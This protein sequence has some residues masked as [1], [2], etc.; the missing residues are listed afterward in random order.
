[1]NENKKI[2]V[3]SFIIFLRLCLMTFIGIFTSRI[4]LDKLGASDFG[5]YNVVGGVVLLLNIVNTSML[6]TTYRYIAFELGKEGK[7]N[8]NKVFNA[9]FAI[10]GSY[11]LLIL[12]LGFTIGDWYVTNYINLPDG[13]LDDALFVFHLSLLAASINTLL[14]PFRGLLV[15]FENFSIS[16]IIDVIAKILYFISVVFILTQSDNGLI[17]YG[18]IHTVVVI[19]ESIGYYIYSQIKFLDIIRFRIVKEKS[20][21]K[22]MF[23]FSVWT[24]YGAVSSVGRAQGSVLI[25]NYFFGTLVNAAYA[26][27][28]QVNNFIK[29]FAL[30]LNNAAVPQITKNYSGGNLNRSVDLACYISKYTFILMTLVAFPVILEMDFLLSLWLKEVPEGTTEFCQWMILISLITTIGEGIYPLV[31]A[32]GKLKTFQLILCT[33]SLLGL[34]IAYIIYYLGTP[35]ISILILFFLMTFISLFIRL[36]LFL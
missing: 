20:I 3:N 8:T 29:S 22:G 21:Y 35:P 5:L 17:I 33:F 7:G 18:L 36:Y 13:R 31:Q 25:I 26:V 23:S 2:A 19:F 27:A 15:A 34:P 12:L 14:V 1:M 30:S 10:H 9:S 28:V 11:G 32:S 4:V 16:T 6:S 24:L